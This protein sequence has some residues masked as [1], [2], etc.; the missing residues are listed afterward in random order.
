MSKRN[1]QVMEIVDSD[2]FRELQDK[3]QAAR[4]RKQRQQDQLQG[5]DS[6]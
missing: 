2:F 3:A 5:S 4:E 1:A 6:E